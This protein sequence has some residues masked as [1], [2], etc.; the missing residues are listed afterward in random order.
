M[1]TF[2]LKTPW[3]GEAACGV[4]VLRSWFWAETRA[5]TYLPS[6]LFPG[7]KAGLHFPAS[8]AVGCGHVTQ[9]VQWMGWDG[10]TNAPWSISWASPLREQG[11]LLHVLYRLVC[12]DVRCH[13]PLGRRQRH[14]I[15]GT[16]APR[17]LLVW[18]LL[19][20]CKCQPVVL[21]EWEILL[22]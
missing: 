7:H 1:F 6:P 20:N 18:E 16:Q 8:L 10:I 4:K 5:I 12:L 17:S 13:M 19:G 22:L 2:S 21:C 9:N 15:E 11:C 3:D 14:R